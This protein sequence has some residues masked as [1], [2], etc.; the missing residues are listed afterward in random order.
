[1]SSIWN[2]N[3]YTNEELLEFLGLNNPTDRE[4]EAS[5]NQKIEKYLNN[6]NIKLATFYEDI[7]K[8]F[9]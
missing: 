8:R 3:N 6:D 2:V 5:L 9:F 1:M 4:L 7:Y